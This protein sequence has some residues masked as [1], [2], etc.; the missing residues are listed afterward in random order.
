MENIQNQAYPTTQF[1]AKKKAS[2]PSLSLTNSTRVNKQPNPPRPVSTL[3]R[4]PTSRAF[5]LSLTDNSQPTQVV[6]QSSPVEYHTERFPIASNPYTTGV[7]SE[8]TTAITTSISFPAQ[9]SPIRSPEPTTPETDSTN[10]DHLF[11]MNTDEVT[12]PVQQLVSTLESPL[13]GYPTSP[14]KYKS[15]VRQRTKFDSDGNIIKKATIDR[16]SPPSPPPSPRSPTKEPARPQPM[17]DGPKVYTHHLV[18][19]ATIPFTT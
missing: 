3:D 6:C 8:D 1:S 9:V 14:E 13:D 18:T 19:S 17:N 10:L 4:K 2:R 7:F 5:D 15:S 12:T 16:H 11:P